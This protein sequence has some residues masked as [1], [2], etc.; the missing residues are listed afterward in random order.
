MEDV[1]TWE[2]DL[3][4]IHLQNNGIHYYGKVEYDM[5]Q[6]IVVFEYGSSELYDDSLLDED[7][8]GMS[9][10]MLW[11]LAHWADNLDREQL[12]SLE[13]FYTVWEENS[14]PMAFESSMQ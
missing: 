9:D 2:D 4:C 14:S 12:I 1:A 10:E 8:E 3:F 5:S 7:G 11:F 6:A 13:E